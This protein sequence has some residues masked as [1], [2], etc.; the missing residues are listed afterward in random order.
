MLF[1]ITEHG[2]VYIVTHKIVSI[3]IPVGGISGLIVAVHAYFKG[4]GPFLSILLGA[5]GAATSYLPALALV[6]V[7]DNHPDLFRYAIVLLTLIYIL[8]CIL[9]AFRDNKATN[10]DQIK[11]LLKNDDVKSTLL[12]PLYYTFKTKSYRYK[13]TKFGLLDEVSDTVNSMSGESVLHY[14][15]WCIMVLVLVMEFLLFSPKFADLNIPF[16]GDDNQATQELIEEEA[17]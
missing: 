12:E 8:I 3:G 4:I 11:D 10:S 16:S 13:S 5:I 1:G 14:V 15:M 9:T 2:R 17:Q 6:W 7:N